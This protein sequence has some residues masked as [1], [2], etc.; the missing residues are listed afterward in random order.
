MPRG[1]GRAA[2]PISGVKPNGNTVT[3]TYYASGLLYQQTE[4]TS[5]GIL[6]SSRQLLSR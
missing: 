4:D 1:R 2:V 6:V 5:G 3:S